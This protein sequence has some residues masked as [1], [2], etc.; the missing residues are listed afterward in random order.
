[1]TTFTLIEYFF[2]ISASAIAKFEYKIVDSAINKNEIFLKIF[3]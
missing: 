2:P 3:S 1:V